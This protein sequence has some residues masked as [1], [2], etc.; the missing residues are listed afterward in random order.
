MGEILIRFVDIIQVHYFYRN[1]ILCIIYLSIYFVFIYNFFSYFVVWRKIKPLNLDMLHFDLFYCDKELLN[2]TI[3]LLYYSLLSHYLCLFFMNSGPCPA[4]IFDAPSVF[5]G[6]AWTQ[7]K[8][9][10]RSRRWWP[11]TRRRKQQ[12]FETS[13]PV[14]YNLIDKLLI[15]KCSLRSD[16]PEHQSSQTPHD[17]SVLEMC[18]CGWRTWCHT[19]AQVQYECWRASVSES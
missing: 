15:I 17:V 14:F 5:V 7:E 11:H 18:V 4:W 1:H 19:N 13:A 16:R 6:R 2:I 12:P 8:P 10:L 9:S 3:F